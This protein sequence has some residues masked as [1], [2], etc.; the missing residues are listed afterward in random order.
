MDAGGTVPCRSLSRCRARY[1]SA[2]IDPCDALCCQACTVPTLYPPPGIVLIDKLFPTIP[3]DLLTA[4]DCLAVIKRICYVM[5][6]Y[7]SN[8][9][10]ISTSSYKSRTSE[11]TNRV[12]YVCFYRLPRGSSGRSQTLIISIAP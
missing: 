5:L 10:C 6:C 3:T 7:A 2:I 4:S 8:S 12:D 9:I 11:T 1:Q